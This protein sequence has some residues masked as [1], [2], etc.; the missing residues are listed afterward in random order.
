MSR[1]MHVPKYF[2]GY[3]YIKEFSTLLYLSSTYLNTLFIDKIMS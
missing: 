2:K 3:E 1:V